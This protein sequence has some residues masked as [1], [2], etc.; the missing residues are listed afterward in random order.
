MEEEQEEEDK[1]Q[2]ERSLLAKQRPTEVAQGKVRRTNGW[3]GKGRAESSRRK[4]TKKKKWK[5]KSRPRE[6][7]YQLTQWSLDRI[8]LDEL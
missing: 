1:E 6:M 7:G 5:P 8:S 2:M 3:L 4:R